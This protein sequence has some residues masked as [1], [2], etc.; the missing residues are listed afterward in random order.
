MASRPEPELSRGHPGVGLRVRERLAP[1]AEAVAVAVA[2]AGLVWFGLR[3]V[4]SELGQAEE[5]VA[6]IGAVPPQYLPLV[7]PF[8]V[9][10]IAIVVGVLLFHGLP[11]HRRRPWLRPTR[12]LPGG[13]L[14]RWSAVTFAASLVLSAA[15]A[16]LVTG[17][18]VLG[19]LGVGSG[20]APPVAVTSV[21]ASL[22]LLLFLGSCRRLRLAW[23]ARMPG[24]ID[25]LPIASA[26]GDA[27]KQLPRDELT[28]LLR[29]ELAHVNLY[30]PSLVPG[31]DSPQDFLG[32]VQSRSEGTGLIAR[33]SRLLSVAWP[34]HAY[35]VYCQ[36][37]T[38]RS[39]AAESEPHRAF[40][41]SVQ[42]QLVPTWLSTPTIHWAPSREEAARAA[43][44][45]VAQELLPWTRAGR[46][47]PWADWVDEAMPAGLVKC[48]ETG[49]QLVAARRYDEAIGAFRDGLRL[50]PKNLEL[51]LEMAH[52]Y[53]KLAL[54]IE[55]LE[56][57]T[58]VEELATR[59]LSDLPRWPLRRK[60][61]CE[62]RA[63]STARLVALYRRTIT[64]TW[65][66]RLAD[67]WVAGMTREP[68]PAWARREREESGTRERLRKSLRT[69]KLAQDLDDV[70]RPMLPAAA[71]SCAEWFESVPRFAAA[72]SAEEAEQRERLHRTLFRLLFHAWADVEARRL[73][74]EYGA[75]RRQLPGVAHVVSRASCRLVQLWAEYHWD[76]ERTRA[77]G[78]VAF[79]EEAVRL[80]PRPREAGPPATRLDVSTEAIAAYV[81]ALAKLRDVRRPPSPRGYDPS[82]PESL[83]AAVGHIMRSRARPRTWLDHYNAACVLASPLAAADWQGAKRDA[84]GRIPATQ[85]VYL[86]LER[87]A[88]DQLRTAMRRTPTG[89]LGN[90]APWV[91]SEDPDLDQLREQESFAIFARRQFPGQQAGLSRPPDA[92]AFELTMRT[93]RTARHSADLV[94]L[95]WRRLAD[96]RPTSVAEMRALLRREERAWH[97]VRLMA[98]N[99]RHVATRLELIEAMSSLTHLRGLPTPD[100]SY[101]AYPSL[102]DPDE[103]PAACGPL[104]DAA[105]RR[106]D[107]ILARLGAG[108]PRQQRVDWLEGTYRVMLAGGSLTRREWREVALHQAGLWYQLARW[109]DDTDGDG[110]GIAAGEAATSLGKPRWATGEPRVPGPR[111]ATHD[112]ASPG[113][114]S[115]PQDTAAT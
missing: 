48:Y 62:R 100:W 30:T 13:G 115:P 29:R 95:D 28:A 32:L 79:L 22:A 47:P 110:P 25:V 12:P 19:R 93:V 2:V 44:Y 54:W 20:D 64:L 108:D 76:E 41:I 15:T 49:K 70:A 69:D 80:G 68:Q 91:C 114:G 24:P 58:H 23:L 96:H 27:D 3:A 74:T 92:H 82:R 83:H 112:R 6:A 67:Q 56:I 102:I 72:P 34:T 84:T 87:A 104:V 109:L 66:E 7:T 97:L 9:A 75:G 77:D 4:G 55:A 78:V 63:I 31:A 38:P 18:R 26:T 98:R 14:F 88:I 71:P 59:R 39:G 8:A 43:A 17:E 11:L 86:D 99:H 40:G 42:V 61:R 73:M 103:P 46:Q 45:A 5:A 81:T 57:Y 50:D 94:S 65:G 16:L 105:N 21:A 101:P 37:L 35:R 51:R 85:R 33:A 52:V 53:Q 113:T 60:P 36:T 106:L 10:T 107:Q 1:V 89:A 90:L 111:P